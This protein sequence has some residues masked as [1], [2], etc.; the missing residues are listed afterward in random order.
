ML[1]EMID[2]Q[3]P[4]AAPTCDA[5]SQTIRSYLR[6]AGARSSLV[7]SKLLYRKIAVEAPIEAIVEYRAYEP[8]D[9]VIVD[10]RTMAR[11]VCWVWFAPGFEFELPGEPWPVRVRLEV[12]VEPWLAIRWLRLEIDGQMVYEEGQPPSAL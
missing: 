5:P 7:N 1:A 12:R 9:R 11:K 10:G 6:K 4:Y 3:N 2:A 8:W